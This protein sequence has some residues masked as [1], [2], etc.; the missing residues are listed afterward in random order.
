MAD[1]WDFF[2]LLVDDQPA[3]IY[4]DLGIVTD[5]PLG[6]YPH[7][8]YVRVEMRHP[9]DDGL[10]SQEEFHDL[11]RLEDDLTA[12][13]AGEGDAIYVGR[14]TSNGCRDFYFYAADAS[15]FTRAAEAAAARHPSY[16]CEIGSRPDPAWTVYFDF[17][18]PS[19]D[20]RQRMANRGVRDALERHGDLLTEARPIDHR[21]YFRSRDAAAALF[22]RLERDGFQVQLPKAM[23]EG[24]YAVDFVRADSPADMDDVAVA[25]A[26]LVYELGGEY[27]G[28][29]CPVVIAKQD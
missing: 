7:M 11:C 17:L 19:D 8:G 20:D 14:N 27:D 18:S 13:I 24:E 12:R 3:S 5:A 25:V 28:W 15:R 6:R 29:G 4:V 1:N 10:S 21:A 2:F 9:R 23:D 22:A 26:R 16:R